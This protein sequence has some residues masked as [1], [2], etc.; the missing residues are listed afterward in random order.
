MLT[1]GLQD[2]LAGLNPDLCKPPRLQEL[3]GGK[4]GA[5]GLQA[6]TGEGIEHDLGKCV[7]VAD[8]E[9]EEAD[10]ERLLDEVGENV[11]VHAPGPEQARERY[12][13]DDQRR[14]EKRDFPAKQAESA[15][16][17]AREDLGKTVDDAGVHCGCP[18]IS[19]S[20]WSAAE[21]GAEG[22]GGALFGNSLANGVAGSFKSG[23]AGTAS[24]TRSR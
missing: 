19:P 18:A 23:V 6:E 1:G 20:G 15:V 10:V 5:R 16:D 9:G 13:D 12:V 11:L 24:V 8:Q 17:V 2:R 7:E 22:D 3:V 14:R 4:S 21:F